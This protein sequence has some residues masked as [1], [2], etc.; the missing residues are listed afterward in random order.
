ML[1]ANSNLVILSSLKSASAFSF[2]DLCWC[3]HQ[4]FIVSPIPKCLQCF[5]FISLSLKK[6]SWV[7]FLWFFFSCTNDVLCSNVIWSDDALQGPERLR[8]CDNLPGIKSFHTWFYQ[9]SI[10][11]SYWAK[12]CSALSPNELF[13][14]VHT[15]LNRNTAWA[16][17][18]VLRASF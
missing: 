5:P 14:T 15:V 9:S 7:L 6:K 12:F 4:S 10:K 18:S 11:T 8:S 17:C 16:K 1:S 3:F 13:L 2:R